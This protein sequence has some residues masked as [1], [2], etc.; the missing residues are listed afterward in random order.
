ML[1]SIIF[2]FEF[3]VNRT[4]QHIF[5]QCRVE[6]G[7]LNKDE[8]M[9]AVKDLY[10]DHLRAVTSREFV[11]QILI[12][13]GILRVEGQLS[14]ATLKEINTH[15]RMLDC[16]FKQCLGGLVI[17]KDFPQRGRVAI[18]CDKV[19]CQNRINLP[20]W[21]IDA[22]E[23]DRQCSQVIY[24]SSSSLNLFFEFN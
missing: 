19:G 15:F 13:T 11:R 4:N 7:T 5:S 20:H 8:G 10:R 6:R 17:K 21:V 9:L 2:I 22:K 16:D 14:R 12:A 18:H 24:F 23:L 3:T 1:H